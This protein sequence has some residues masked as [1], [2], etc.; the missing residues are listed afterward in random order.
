MSS[1]E[2][3]ANESNDSEDDNTS[4]TVVKNKHLRTEEQQS[5]RPTKARKTKSNNSNSHGGSSPTNHKNGVAAD[6]FIVKRISADKCGQRHGPLIKFLDEILR[7]DDGKQSLVVKLDD[8]TKCWIDI[9][10][11]CAPDVINMVGMS[12]VVMILCLDTSCCCVKHS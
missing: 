2:K 5:P 3:K 6:S 4:S 1:T 9:N 11:L 7:V 8:D 10:T 12:L